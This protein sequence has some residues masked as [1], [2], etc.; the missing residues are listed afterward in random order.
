VQIEPNRESSYATKTPPLNRWSEVL[1]VS[2]DGD[3]LVPG[4]PPTGLILPPDVLK[5]GESLPQREER[6]VAGDL[7]EWVT[8]MASDMLEL[9][10]LLEEFVQGPPVRLPRIAL[11]DYLQQAVD[12][13]D[14]VRTGDV[15]CGFVMLVTLWK[16]LRLRAE[17]F[18]RAAGADKNLGP[19][20]VGEEAASL[21]QLLKCL[22]VFEGEIDE[23]PWEFVDGQISHACPTEKPVPVNPPDV[24]SAFGELDVTPQ[25]SPPELDSV[26]GSLK[27]YEGAVDGESQIE[28]NA[29]IVVGRGQLTLGIE[30]LDILTTKAHW[31]C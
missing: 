10:E 11:Q 29:T 23:K 7:R 15:G 17:S 14:P 21:P 13:L 8:P 24:D 1:V 9:A 18:E 2:Y 12:P 19:V 16:S 31:E 30:P 3:K 22:P 4:P 25:R 28:Y 27:P 26:F 5:D 20:P 6:V